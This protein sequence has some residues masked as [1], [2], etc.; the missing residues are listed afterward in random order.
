[1]Q[2]ETVRAAIET[3]LRPLVR[4]MTSMPRGMT[5]AFR[6]LSGEG[7]NVYNDPC[8]DPQQTTGDLSGLD[9]P[10]GKRGRRDY[11]RRVDRIA[12]ARLRARPCCIGARA[13]VVGSVFPRP[14]WTWRVVDPI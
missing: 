9:R 4:S 1:P 12:P 5:N 7:V 3:V 8:G 10:A 13:T 11:R 6:S 14:Q 2:N